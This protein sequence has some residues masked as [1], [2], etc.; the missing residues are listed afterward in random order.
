LAGALKNATSIEIARFPSETNEAESLSSFA[1]EAFNIRLTD[2][3][4]IVERNGVNAIFE[5]PAIEQRNIIA[6]NILFISSANG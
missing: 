3:A 5:M 1:S 4:L 2:P 6:L